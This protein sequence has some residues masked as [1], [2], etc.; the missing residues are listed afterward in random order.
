MHRWVAIEILFLDQLVQLALELHVACIAPVRVVA[1]GETPD[2]TLRDLDSAVVR[3]RA[4]VDQGSVPLD[5]SVLSHLLHVTLWNLHG[6]ARLRHYSF[7]LLPHRE[8]SM[9]CL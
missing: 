4:Q 8:V 7:P 1:V 3:Y 6:G 5:E 2:K 9:F